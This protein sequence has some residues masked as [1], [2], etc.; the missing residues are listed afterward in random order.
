[1]KKIHRRSVL[2]GIS[3]F[4]AASVL[5]SRKPAIAEA[6]IKSG[7][8]W[9]AI[10]VG[11]GV[12]GS[13]TAVNLQRVGK[14]VLLVDSSGPAN[15]RAS[16]GGET[17]MIRSSYGADD[18]YT[19]MSLRSLE[20][21]K[22]LSDSA[23]LPLFHE[24]GVLF[25]FQEMADYARASIEVHNKLGH[26]LHVLDHATLKR[27]FPQVRT[28]DIDFALYEPGFGALM[29]RRAIHHLLSQYVKAGGYYVQAKMPSPSAGNHSVT[30]NG[31]KH[32]ADAVIYACGPWMPK[33]FPEVLEE[34][35][36]VTRQEV[37][38]IAP[39][40]GDTRFTSQELAGWAD[41]NNGNLFY[42]FPDIENRGFKIAH[43]KHGPAFDPDTGDRRV[44]DKGYNT[45]KDYVATRFPA[46]ADR[47]FIG[48]RVCQ[49]TNSSSGDFLIDKHPSYGGVYLVGAGSGHGFKH[50]PEIGRMAA[51]MVLNTQKAPHARFSLSSKKN[52]HKRSVV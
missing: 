50:G 14:R 44:T 45:L 31:N 27:K 1:M 22:A 18:I 13:W 24:T 39:P 21:W 19:R 46:L 7:N 30:I 42:G 52:T 23:E 12:F 16:S 41:F 35:I 17:R 9:D 15:V 34:R 4:G 40:E 49:Y 43:D 51:N 38:F 36:F 33:L 26:P 3:A 10:V 28:N 20:E 6:H 5:T 8:T 25:M 2:K 37:A 48:E 29:A 47:P 11:A 32:H